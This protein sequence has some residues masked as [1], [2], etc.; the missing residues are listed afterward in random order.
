MSEQLLAMLSQ[1]A[2]LLSVGVM[3]LAVLRPLLLRRLGAGS[4]YAA[5]L[6][7]PAIL[8][9]PLLPRPAQ[10]PL[11]VVMQV[12]GTAETATIPAV[13]VPPLDQTSMWLALW[14]VGASLVAATQAWQ[15]WRLARQGL[16]LPAGSSPALVGLLRPVVALPIDFEQRFS[17]AERALI[18][19]H[20]NVHRARGDNAWNLLACALRA[21]HWWNP[22]VWWAMQ[23][24][25]ADQELACDAAV[26]VR[27]PD[28]LADYKRALLAAHNLTPHGA[29]LASRWG[30]AHPLV[31]RIEML[32]HLTPMNRRRAGAMTL[33]LA[34]AAGLAYAAQTPQLAPP[35]AS[36]DAVR[37]TLLLIVQE[38][39]NVRRSSKVVVGKVGQRMRV[40]V[41]IPT[42]ASGF[43]FDVTTISLDDEGFG[44]DITAEGLPKPLSIGN[45]RMT[46]WWEQPTLLESIDEKG[47]GRVSM[48][49]VGKRVTATPSASQPGS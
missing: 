46:A 37:L 8:L 29:P 22:L 7:V 27:R 49:I 16:Q 13:P 36:G 26:L 14:L 21:L 12:A 40:E 10:E 11:H 19:A 33:L 20:E 24:L 38:G 17:A 41:D 1:Q 6:L 15:Q 3:T 34:S 32:N 35:P 25:R 23:R 47:T 4:A 5:W 2:V 18:L 28:A 39:S 30:T 42:K 48:F 9:T 43:S 44:L 31:E 45:P